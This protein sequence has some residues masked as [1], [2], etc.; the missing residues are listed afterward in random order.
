MSVLSQAQSLWMSAKIVLG[1]MEQVLKY[2]NYDTHPVS[3]LEALGA[4]DL[5]KDLTVD[6]SFKEF[7]LATGFQVPL[8][9]G[10]IPVSGEKGVW[11]VIDFNCMESNRSKAVC[12]SVL[13]EE[14]KRFGKTEL[15]N[16]VQDRFKDLLI[17]NA[18]P[19]QRIR[20]QLD[21]KLADVIN[22]AILTIDYLS[23]P[24]N[25]KAT[26]KAILNQ[27]AI[28]KPPR[29]T[30]DW[31]RLANKLKGP[32]ARQSLAS[33]AAYL[34]GLL[35]CYKY[36]QVDSEMARLLEKL[37]S[38]ERAVGEGGEEI[39][40]RRGFDF[41]IPSRVEACRKRL[42]ELAE[43]RRCDVNKVLSLFDELVKGEKKGSSK[44][45]AAAYALWQA[46]RDEG[47]QQKEVVALFG[48]TPQV[49]RYW[50]KR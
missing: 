32:M 28:S 44:I 17:E 36:P 9:L 11:R 49:L 30:K 23:I 39:V 34:A 50:G 27:L 43:L 13:I 38:E 40:V 24:G 33:A 7:V 10:L 12:L 31:Q 26:A 18:V 15:V 42:V 8:L 3:I 6:S 2:L 1:T 5:V 25:V 16:A 35:H 20:S 48:V 37:V 47:V 46:C 41:S 21:I 14:L 29:L 45:V 4:E 19:V 22:G